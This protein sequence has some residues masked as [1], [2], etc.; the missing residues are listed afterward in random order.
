[1]HYFFFQIDFFI[2]IKIRIFFA[3]F[4]DYLKINTL[5]KTFFTP[6][7]NFLPQKKANLSIRFL[8][9]RYTQK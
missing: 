9:L 3:F 6:K 5:D 1:M 7:L 8:I 2:Y 4:A